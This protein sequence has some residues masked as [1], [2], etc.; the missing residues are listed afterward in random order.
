MLNQFEEKYNVEFCKY[1]ASSYK[2]TFD[3]TNIKLSDEMKKK[4]DENNY[5]KTLDNIIKIYNNSCSSSTK[6]YTL[7]S[8]EHIIRNLNMSN[9]IC[10][11]IFYK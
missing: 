9:D 5:T 3:N 2:N 10:Y 7:Y 1:S 8:I 6:K 4:I 11:Q